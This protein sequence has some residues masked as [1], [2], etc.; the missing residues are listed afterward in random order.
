MLFS[1]HRSERGSNQ[2]KQKAKSKGKGGDAI[3]GEGGTC[4]EM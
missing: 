4:D 2:S 3:S 1:I